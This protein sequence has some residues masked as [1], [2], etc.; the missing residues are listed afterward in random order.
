MSFSVKNLVPT[1]VPIGSGVNIPLN[2]DTDA[3]VVTLNSMRLRMTMG[4][5]VGNRVYVFVFSDAASPPNKLYTAFAPVAVAGQ[6][7]VFSF[8]GG[9]P[10]AAVVGSGAYAADSWATV[11]LPVNFELPPGAV[12]NIHDGNFVDPTDSLILGAAVIG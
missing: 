4:P 7:A 8:G 3:P 10:L 6:E 2:S 12:L 5:V 1:A 9:V 11:P